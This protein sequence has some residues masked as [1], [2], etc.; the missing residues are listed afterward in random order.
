LATTGTDWLAEEDEDDLTTKR[1]I[2]EIAAPRSPVLTLALVAENIDLAQLGL[3]YLTNLRVFL[4][5]A[6]ATVH[7]T[8]TPTGQ[9]GL[10]QTT[11]PD[12]ALLAGFTPLWEHYRTRHLAGDL[13]RMVQDIIAAMDACAMRRGGGVYFVPYAQRPAL[14][15]LKYLL[16]VALCPGWETNS[17]LVHL[18]I[19]DQPA[20]RAQLASIAHT[21]FL[22]E[23]TALQKDLERFSAQAQTT[24]QRGTA[25]RIKP[26][27]MRSR[28][29]AYQGMQAR[30][31]R[32]GTLLGIQQ[33]A[34]R[35]GLAQLEATARRLLQTAAP[36]PHGEDGTAPSD[37]AV[38]CE[39][40]PLGSGR[41]QVCVASRPR[42]HD[43][44][45]IRKRT[46]PH[47][48]VACPTTVPHHCGPVRAKP[49]MR[50]GHSR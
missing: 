5:K 7:L 39:A 9:D 4:D 18:P 22:R 46:F 17:R 15:R 6:T 45:Q 28:L 10:R 26:Q 8:T 36:A 50:R 27:S 48:A 34:L 25:G 14:Q 3:S 41:A 13:G 49:T 42:R 32:Y 38:G 2:R 40:A 23:L 24:T 31:E 20:T 35:R 12:Q 30:I 16:E 21:S 11:M 37:V 33:H 1:L 29:A 43:Q 19:V 44:G 47:E